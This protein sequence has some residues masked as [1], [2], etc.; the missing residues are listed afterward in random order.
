MCI[1]ASQE[2][3]PER[4]LMAKK[5]KFYVVWQGRQTGIFSTWEECKKQVT[6]FATARYKSFENESEARQAFTAGPP[7]FSTQR[8]AK[9][10]VVATGKPIMVSISVDAACSGNPGIMEYQGVETSTKKRLFHGGPF[11]E[12]TNNIGEF[13]AIVHGL[14]YLKRNN[15][16]IPLYTDSK[17]AIAWVRNKKANTKIKPTAENA[18]LLELVTRAENWLHNNSWNN[19]ILKW[20]TTVWG[21][22]PADF[23]R[24]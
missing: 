5:Q 18:A 9:S 7:R 17:T 16:S 10:A 4:Q 19:P 3:K 14:S 23:G 20:E 24:K 12:G 1:F 8:P 6:G 11:P 13:L 21:E 2:S 15:Q 22:I